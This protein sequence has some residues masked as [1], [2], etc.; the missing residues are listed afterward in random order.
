MSCG[1]SGARCRWRSLLAFC[2][3]ALPWPSLWAWG[4]QGHQVVAEIA[5]Q[6]L[7]TTTRMRVE[8]LL[9]AEPG[10]SLVSLSTWADAH[11][12]A[13]SARWHYV[14][15]PRGD[16]DFQAERDCPDGQC[17]VAAIERF[18]AVLASQANDAERLLA[19]KYLVHFVADIHQ[20]LHAGYRDDRG[21]NTVQLRFLMRGSNLHAL[22]DT[23]LIENLGLG[24]A[25]LL[26]LVHSRSKPLLSPWPG[27]AAIAA[28]SCRIV[29]GGSLYPPRDP[30][31][32]Y[33]RAFTPVA[34]DRLAMAAG[35]LA[36]ILNQALP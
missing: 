36:A 35:R 34:L 3:F 13:A 16:C 26:A 8:R 1:T 4:V 25:A 29:A 10:Q 11:R 20:P 31:D 12:G 21:G 32:A 2:I 5:W 19:L 24:N 18:S 6:S 9:A 22:W 15:F 30:D 17:V 27:A 28:E 23:G 33:V 14:N 7:Q